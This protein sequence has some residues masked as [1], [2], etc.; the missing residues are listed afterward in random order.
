MLSPRTRPDPIPVKISDL[1]TGVEVPQGSLLRQHL[2]E[3]RFALFLDQSLLCEKRGVG[4]G[5][6]RVGI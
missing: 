4:V 5:A 3:A 6:R 1:F 2:R